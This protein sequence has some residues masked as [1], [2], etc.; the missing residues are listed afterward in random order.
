MTGTEGIVRV[1]GPTIRTRVGT[2]FDFED[3]EAS[4]IVLADIAHALGNI[5]RFNGHTHRFYSVAEHSVHCSYLVPEGDA[6]AA[7]MHDAVEAY[8]GDVSRP[9]K[10]LLPGYK[11]IERRVEAAVLAR[12]GVPLPLPASVK[13]ADM[14]ML[15]LEQRFAM[16]CS[17]LWPGL[18]GVPL[19]EIALRFWPPETAAQ[20]FTQRAFD[21][22]VDVV[23]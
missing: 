2:Y 14:M 19:P 5:C 18:D 10:S 8:V 12:F 9:L 23:S 21:L 1:K 20:R 17:D 13:R 6:A 11:E 16:E 3:P 7:L 4:E 15:R 22:G